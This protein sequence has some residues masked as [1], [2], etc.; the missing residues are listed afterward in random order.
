MRPETLPSLWAFI[1]TTLLALACS[2]LPLSGS[3]DDLSSTSPN[4]KARALN[5]WFTCF[6][7]KTTDQRRAKFNDCAR[8]A[9]QLPNLIDAK[10][11]HRGGDPGSDPYS[12]P[13]VRVHNS[14]QVK[15]DLRFGRSDESSWLA[16]NM[17]LS[18]IMAAC[19]VGYGAYESTGGEIVAGNG[20]FI[21]VT[22]ERRQPGVLTTAGEAKNM[23]DVATE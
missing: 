18:K 19:S 8:A 1:I 14:C 3:S 21:I 4:I 9:A 23:T 22:V 2:T 17:V 13:Q 15:V 12:L 11:F 16:I 6:D 20:D 10:L 7:T 5:N